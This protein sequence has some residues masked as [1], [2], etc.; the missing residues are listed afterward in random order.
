MIQKSKERLL[1]T[2]NQHKEEIER[3][4]KELAESNKR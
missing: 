4:Q 3:L 2:T 1:E